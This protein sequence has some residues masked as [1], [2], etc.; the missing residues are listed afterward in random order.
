[1]ERRALRLLDVIYANAVA[2]EIQNLRREICCGCKTYEQ[3]CFM[4]TEEEGW[5]MHGMTAIEQVNAHHSVWHEFLNV[6]GI[7]NIEVD[8]EFAD[9]LMGVQK[10][11][12]RY[13]VW[14]LLR[15]HENNQALANI[16]NDLLH[17]PAQPLESYNIGYFSS[18]GSYK[19]Y[20][21]GSD[22]TFQSYEKDHQKAYHG[23][24]ENKL[25]EHFNKLI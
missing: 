5:D 4:M 9:H 20:V 8:K 13:F 2:R 6:L 7:L 24:L 17:P 19:Y 15:L 18:P 22:E 3:D 16:L 14:N 23:H 1:M 10:D 25:R 21:K 11:P 12:D